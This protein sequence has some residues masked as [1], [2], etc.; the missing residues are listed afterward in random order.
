MTIGVILAAGKGTRLQSTTHNKTSL[1][2]NGKPII[3]YGIELFEDTT[4]KTMVVVGAFADSVKEVAKGHDNLYFA[5]Q[6]EQ[7]GT[8]DAIRVAIDEIE[9]LQLKPD[10]VL[11]GYGD[12][13]MYY[14]K[15]MVLDIIKLH[16]EKQATITMIVTSMEHPGALGRIVRDEHGHVAAI[17]EYKDATD[18][19]RAITEINPGFYCFDYQF[20]LANYKKLQKSEVTG[21]YYLT[22]FVGMAVAEQK[23]VAALSVPFTYV[24]IGINTK[25]ELEQSQ[26]FHKEVASL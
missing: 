6:A 17:V 1:L 7:L 22:D 15:E 4:D 14:P 20:L 5:H 12:H 26:T 2:F 3:N 13:M 16:E 9:R 11:V 10:R 24:G 8:G 23:I 18:E 25:D 19:Q 21:E